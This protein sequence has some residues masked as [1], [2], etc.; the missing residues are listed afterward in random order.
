MS[1]THCR[2]V[3]FLLFIMAPIVFLSGPV[4]AQD[5]FQTW[6]SALRQEALARGISRPILDQALAG[7][8]PIPRVLELDRRQPEFT[9][10]LW[11]YL[12]LT[13]SDKRIQRGRDLLKRH[14]RLLGEIERA[15]GVQPRFLVAFWGL[16]TN[17][18]D[19]LG[20]FPV[21]GSLATLAHDPRRSD[22]FRNELF[23]ALRIL[24]QGDIRVKA[25]RGSW[26]GA[27]GQLQ[28]MPSTFV[29]FAVDH[30]GDGRKDIWT[31]LPDIFSS[32]ANFLA[33]SGWQKNKTWGQEVRLPDNFDLALADLKIKKTRQQWQELGVSG[34][35]GRDLAPADDIASLMLPAGVSGP[36]FLVFRNYRVILNWNRSHL[37]A[38]AVGHLADR[39][40]GYGPLI[41]QRPLNDKPLHRTDIMKIQQLLAEQGFDPGSVD[42]IAGGRTR[43][44]IKAFQRANQLPMDGYPSADLLDRL[45]ASR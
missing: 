8:K 23:M 33:S 32:A 29:R 13:V 36:A 43:M 6:L 20:G 41:S 22:F 11:Q 19:H 31:S 7:L 34:M 17:F 27:M 4:R 9:K 16:E 26:A 18:G 24:D 30:D 42:G 14:A 12:D 40:A 45:A 21:V 28:F 25:M 15:Y 2:Y 5:D 10:S 38:I 1:M 35:D 37:Y 3:L 39:L 44:A